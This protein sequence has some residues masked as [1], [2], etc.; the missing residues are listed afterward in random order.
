MIFSNTLVKNEKMSLVDGI[1]YLRS[2]GY[3]SLLQVIATIKQKAGI[4]LGRFPSDILNLDNDSTNQTHT[5][6]YAS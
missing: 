1:R 4:D 3:H 2:M 6:D 5:N